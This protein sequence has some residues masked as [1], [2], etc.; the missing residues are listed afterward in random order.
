VLCEHCRWAWEITS[1]DGNWSNWR[2]GLITRCRYIDTI[3]ERRCKTADVQGN[4]QQST[5]QKS[6]NCLNKSLISRHVNNH[7]IPNTIQISNT[8][9]PFISTAHCI[10][11]WRTCWRP[12][13]I[14]LATSVQNRELFWSFGGSLTP[15]KHHQLNTNLQ[16]PKGIRLF[17]VHQTT[18][19]FCHIKNIWTDARCLNIASLE[20][21]DVGLL[22]RGSGSPDCPDFAHCMYTCT[23]DCMQVVCTEAVNYCR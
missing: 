11:V 1:Q 5:K 16:W 20:A 18:I 10:V 22:Q 9:G 14:R 3:T 19:I 4:V 13:F 17:S 6:F 12:W 23:V 8:Y 2:S 15:Q 7:F 21:S